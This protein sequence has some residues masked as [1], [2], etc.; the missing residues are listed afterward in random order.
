[1]TFDPN[2]VAIPNLHVSLRICRYS[3][4]WTDSKNGIEVFGGHILEYFDFSHAFGVL[5]PVIKL[6]A[7]ITLDSFRNGILETKPVSGI[8]WDMSKL[9]SS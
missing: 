6:A 2:L 9:K 8:E 3:T 5:H 4:F 7:C 1:V